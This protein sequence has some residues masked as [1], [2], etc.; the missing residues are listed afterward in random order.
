M[1]W[2]LFA[3]SVIMVVTMLLVLSWPAMDRYLVEYPHLLEVEKLKRHPAY[4][5]FKSM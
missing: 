1:S 3:E 5:K 4:E 2:I